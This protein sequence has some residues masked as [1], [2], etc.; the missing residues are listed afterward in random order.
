MN[1][2]IEK[3]RECNARNSNIQGKEM[4][5]R[6]RSTSIILNKTC[7]K[8]RKINANFSISSGAVTKVAFMGRR[9]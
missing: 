6:S 7:S 5:L 3:Y 2:F 8:G 9:F 1:K 4:I